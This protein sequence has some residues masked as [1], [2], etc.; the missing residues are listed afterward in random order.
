M[1]FTP[2]LR[3]TI[4]RRALVRAPRAV[5]YHTR[6]SRRVPQLVQPVSFSDKML[7]RKVF[8]RDPLH[9]AMT[10]KVAARDVARERLPD[11]QIPE[12][13]WIGEHI[14]ELPLEA[15]DLPYI[16]KM[17]DGSGWYEVVTDVRPE[18][19]TRVRDRFRELHRKPPYG[20]RRG[21]WAYGEFPRR[22][23]A[24]RLLLDAEGR[25]PDDH[26]LY[27]CHGEMV[28]MHV[29]HDRWG[30]MALTHFDAS[31]NFLPGVE[32]R[33]RKDHMPDNLDMF[34]QVVAAGKALAG[35]MDFV[36][37]DLYLHERS[38]WFGEFTIYPTGGF[39]RWSP[40]MLRSLSS[41]W[42]IRSSWYLRSG[43]T[44]ASA[45]LSALDEARYVP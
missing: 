27:F 18:T 26:K 5:W 7:W 37:V 2:G 45:Y 39:L 15:L 22:V 33:H 9:V 11:V 28:H 4:W 19:V 43:D 31:R 41:H 29:T 21:E 3:R 12:L 34:E 42:D 16:V 35:D 40:D 13:L 44:F 30:R 23:F 36:R 20:W 38:V 8:D 24:E 14:D 32:S 25:P 10:D 17:T 6:K 1:G